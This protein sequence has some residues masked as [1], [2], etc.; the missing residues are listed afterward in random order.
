MSRRFENTC[1]VEG[2]GEPCWKEVCR[3]CARRIRNGTLPEQ[4]GVK[5]NPKCE[6]TGC[7]APTA[8]TK[9]KICRG[10]QTVKGQGRPLESKRGK[11]RALE[12][13][14]QCIEPGCI[15]DS[16]T[17]GKCRAH[18]SK[19][20]NPPTTKPCKAE[21]CKAWSK[22]EMCKRHGGQYERYGFT[23]NEEYPK[24]RISR[25]KEER[26]PVCK[27]HRCNRKAS[28]EEATLCTRH[29]NDWARKNCSEDF[30][31]EMMKVEQCESCGAYED[32]VTDH[33]HSC[34]HEKDR[35]CEGCIRGR[36]CHGCNTSLG[37][38]GEDKRRILALAEYLNKH[39]G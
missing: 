18:Y 3:G 9:V 36:L 25:W 34:L 19:E 21:G 31:E 26:K 22:N 37:L 38:L 29:R 16:S 7:N 1:T 35:M 8:T 28:S 6:V 15:A 4:G 39:T 11:R 14:A 30:Y 33:D 23:W 10:H 32:L 27:I 12:D 24:E 5:A 17:K 2:C 13:K 20:K